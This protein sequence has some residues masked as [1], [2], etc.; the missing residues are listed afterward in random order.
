MPKQVNFV[1]NERVD[2]NDLTYGTS[3]FTADSLKAHVQR[4]ISGDY[5]GGFVLEGFRVEVSDPTS[6]VILVHN[7][8]AL[9]RDGRLVTTE[10]GDNF[11]K[12]INIPKSYTLTTANVDHYVMVEFAFD[13]T[14]PDTRAVWDP[15]YENQNITDSAGNTHAAPNGKEFPLNIPTRRAISW[16]IVVVPSGPF[17]DRADLGTEGHTLRIPVAIIPV[18]GGS[19][20]V[21]NLDQEKPWTSVIETPQ[22]DA[23][24]LVCGNTRLF[25]DT[26]RIELRNRLGSLIFGATLNSGYGKNDNDNNVIASI[27]QNG[28][29]TLFEDVHAGDVV[30][31]T[32]DYNGNPISDTF[33][34]AGSKWDARPMLLSFTDPVA[35]SQ[36]TEN[37]EREPRNQKYYA[38]I[39]LLRKYVTAF[40]SVSYPSATASSFKLELNDETERVE[41]NLKQGQDLLR[42]LGALIREMKYGSPI[43]LYY[44]NA[45]GPIVADLSAQTGVTN[46]DQTF[47]I[48]I[49]AD[50]PEFHSGLNTFS[51]GAT[52]TFTSTTATAALQDESRVIT[53]I[54]SNVHNLPATPDFFFYIVTVDSA[55]PAIPSIVIEQFS[56]T[57]GIESNTKFVDNYNIGN[58]NEVYRARIDRIANTWSAD[59]Q[60]RLAANKVPVVTVGDGLNT[61]GD[62]V[63]DGGLVQAFQDVANLDN[64]G[65][66]YIKRGSYTLSGITTVKSNTIVM[67]E[68][69]KTT[70]INLS[71]TSYYIVLDNI[72]SGSYAENIQFKDISIVGAAYA[73]GGTI[74]GKGLV[75]SNTNNVSSIPVRNLTIDNCYLVGGSYWNNTAPAGFPEKGAFPI[76][77]IGVDATDDFA[78]ENIKILNSRFFVAGSGLYL[79]GCR[80]VQI[81]D[82]IFETET[83]ITGA[84]DFIGLV[85][86]I[87]IDGGSPTNNDSEYGFANGGDVE[88]EVRIS[89]CNFRGQ[90]TTLSS[91]PY[92][93][94]VFFS[95]TFTGQN[96]VVSNCQFIGDTEGDIGPV[97]PHPR[98]QAAQI[99]SGIGVVVESGETVAISGCQFH[100]YSEG[101][102]CGSGKT[103]ISDCNFLV[104]T[105]GIL[106]GQPDTA[107][108][109]YD[110]EYEDVDPDWIYS[111]SLPNFITEIKGCSFTS[112]FDV[113]INIL[114]QQSF[115]VSSISIKSCNFSTITT[116]ISYNELSTYVFTQ[117]T[118]PLTHYQFIEVDSCTYSTVFGACVLGGFATNQNSVLASARD[119]AIESF[120]YTNNNHVGVAASNIGSDV[121]NLSAQN[122]VVTGNT[123]ENVV[124]TTVQET[125]FS[126]SAPD[127]LVFDNNTMIDCYPSVNDAIDVV[128]HVIVDLLSSFPKLQINN[129]NISNK[130]DSGTVGICNGIFV[131]SAITQDNS[132]FPNLV[133]SGNNF[134]MTNANYVFLAKQ[135]SGPA[136]TR[137][138]LWDKVSLT[139]NSVINEVTPDRIPNFSSYSNDALYDMPALPG[140]PVQYLGGQSDYCGV[141]DLRL[142]KPYRGFGESTTCLVSGNSIQVTNLFSWAVASSQKD[143]AILVGVR[144][145]N[146]PIEINISDNIT[147]A[148]V[149]LNSNWWNAVSD[150]A[151]AT[152][153]TANINVSNNSIISTQG[154]IFPCLLDIT[155]ASGVVQSGV[156]QPFERTKVS[157]TGNII[158]S[159]SGQ[160]TI[161]VVSYADFYNVV[162]LGQLR[163]VYQGSGPVP[164][165]DQ[166]NTNDLCFSWLISDNHFDGM[167]IIIGYGDAAEESGTYLGTLTFSTEG[168]DWAGGGTVALPSGERLIVVENNQFSFLDDG[169]NDGHIFGT[170]ERL[171]IARLFCGITDG[172]GPARGGSLMH[173]LGQAGGGSLEIQN[174]PDTGGTAVGIGPYN[175]RSAVIV[176]NNSAVDGYLT[177]TEHAFTGSLI[178]QG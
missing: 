178:D 71:S 60:D 150:P 127:T 155:P 134:D 133:M 140:V 93:G 131:G 65:V 170:T 101:V 4:L 162:R 107:V 14:D 132:I 53:S 104:C 66:I 111:S 28:T 123:V 19:I 166:V 126:I 77:H 171:G 109:S 99:K 175:I 98:Y 121:I 100:S 26:G 90:H 119:W 44:T 124:V 11:S 24:F 52:L 139:N 13:D 103:T 153:Y 22:T 146:F 105:D 51:V 88:G 177:T 72:S 43:N 161:S 20:D 136:L 106:V 54:S 75:I 141:F 35:A 79:Q 8:I 113:G 73:G 108:T 46:T 125:V 172:S 91:L 70:T 86:G 118:I 96:S 85:E 1:P 147:N 94:W 2:L 9:D 157:I 30:I 89:N 95:P 117:P 64:G 168:V 167:P 115:S 160:D 143:D 116:G 55:F 57:K 114:P 142:F 42:S 69:S 148:P 80:N 92:R 67:G 144:I 176:Q 82:C 138:F 33:V 48:R 25:A 40:T 174:Y 36:E 163:G 41:N 154:D 84:G 130:F 151:G 61:F 112:R 6:R 50:H 56:L 49:K 34:E 137:Q 39:A 74:T 29:S 135:D 59:L 32:Q 45:F 102:R 97:S 68:G 5:N 169:H 81:D 23:D 37:V 7:G 27:T 16:R 120:N 10:D 83:N 3:T 38:A 87:V 76:I 165:D 164:A 158:E 31:M 58:L 156:L 78:S 149:I 129:N 15:T 110:F 17:S 18:V 63:G 145:S 173:I 62:Y 128:N 21:A 122:C 159:G 47:G 152:G 12:N